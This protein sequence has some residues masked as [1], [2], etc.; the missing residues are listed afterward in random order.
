MGGDDDDEWDQDD[1]EEEDWRKALTKTTKD[2]AKRKAK[3]QIEQKEELQKKKSEARPP[4]AAAA[5]AAAA[6]RLVIHAVT[7][8]CAV[9]VHYCATCKKDRRD[10]WLDDDGEVYCVVCWRTYHREAPP[11]QP[12][13]R[14]AEVTARTRA[15]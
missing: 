3:A 12:T 14:A 15:Q 4:T 6:P 7:R 5:A 1:E 2:S 9:Q 11:G 8:A 10:L 13:M